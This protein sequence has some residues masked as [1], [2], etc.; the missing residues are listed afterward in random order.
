M[1]PVRAIPPRPPDAK[2]ASCGSHLRISRSVRGLLDNQPALPRV[3]TTEAKVPKREE[4]LPP[5]P[6]R[7]LG[8][9]QWIDAASEQDNVGRVGVPDDV[10]RVVLFC[11][12]DLAI[13]MTGS[14]VAVDAGDLSL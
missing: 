2:R 12:G 13:F 7:V 6:A 3:P 9:Q 11:A 5:R 8:S 14:T 4:S 1:T 10:A